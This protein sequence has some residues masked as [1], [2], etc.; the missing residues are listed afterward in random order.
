MNRTGLAIILLV[1]TFFLSAHSIQAGTT[2]KIVGQIIDPDTGD[3]LPGAQVQIEGTRIGTLTDNEGHYFLLDVSPG[4]YSVTASLIGHQKVTKNEVEVIVDGTTRVD[5]QLNTVVI[6]MP[7]M[8]ITA[9]RP[10]L[11]KDITSSIK[12]VSEKKIE[13]LPVDR[14]EDILK[15]QPGFVTD[16]SNQLHIRGGRTDEIAYFIDGIPVENSLFGGINSL[17]N[18]DSIDQ[19]LILTGTFN[20]EY[21]DAQ[22]AVVN[23]VTKEGESTFHGQVEYKS[24][25]VNDSPYREK[26]WAG[27]GVDSQ[28]DPVTNES[29]YSRPDV[30]DQDVRLPLPGSFSAS[31]SGPVAGIND[32]TF[33]LATRSNKENSHLPFGYHLEE[34]LNWKLSYLPGE[35]KKLTIL[36]QNSQNEFQNYSHSWK[37]RP[38]SRATNFR[39]SDRVGAI[40]NQSIGKTYYLSVIGSRDRQFYD[41]VVGDKNP[42][43]YVR[44]QTDPSL[45]FYVE[46]DDDIFRRSRITTSL[47]KADLIHQHGEIHEIKTGGEFKL[48]DIA[49]L[50]FEEPWFNLE[51]NYT[52]RPIEG[53]IYMQDKIEYDF[54]ILNAGLRFDFVNSRARMWSDPE[55]PES[56]LVDVPV[57]SQLSP[58]IGLS[59]PV[60]DRSI[61]YFSYGHFF[62]NPEY[63]LF[64]SDTRN[65][66]PDNLD[67]LSFGNVGNRNI[68]PQKTVAYEVGVKQEITNELGLGITAFFKDINNLIGSEEVRITTDQSSYHYTYFTNIDYANVKGFEVTL[69]RRYN[70]HLAWDLNYTYSIA[71]GNRSFPL[72]GFFNVYFQQEEE[73]QDFFLDFDR[74]HVI[75]ADITL[76]SENWEGPEILGFHPLARTGLSS[77]VQYAS[78]LPYT[79]S[80]GVPGLLLEKNSARLPWTGTVDLNLF[81]DL[82]N[83]NYRQ[84]FFV[85]ITNLFDRRNVRYVDPLTGELWRT[86]TGEGAT[87]EQRDSAFDPNDVGPPRII[88][89][90][91]RASF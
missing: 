21:G 89:I 18:D 15:I 75:S 83:S 52:Q 10:L 72:E 66:D 41:T 55:N 54:F 58:R 3:L 61:I 31:I 45:S 23:V 38:E 9:E 84:T 49:L 63:S 16:E 88:R 35:G 51:E 81:K 90:G 79:P 37:Y 80:S 13:T 25:M 50:E 27:Q 56:P 19:L 44:S 65:L 78:G 69:D 59:H 33:Y 7:V 22:S 12:V 2:G 47:G 14:L 74:R 34:D 68:K 17:L 4:I 43:E 53:A 46:G 32:L 29:L 67:D 30:F 5:F 82:W 87:I 91:L 20:A 76:N 71:K 8:T 62:Q 48:H 73:N 57:Q 1:A 77:I 85:E 64:F 40:W 6:E 11:R 86:T 24:S 60:T 26:D 36:G 28:R 42:E 70:D 39:L